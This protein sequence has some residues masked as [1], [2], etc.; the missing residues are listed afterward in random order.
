MPTPVSISPGSRAS[1][2]AFTL[3]ELLVVIAIIAVLI[4]LLLPAVQKVREAANRAKCANNLKQMG[5]AVHN[6][7]DSL[8]KL[9]FIRFSSFAVNNTGDN[10]YTWAV[11]LLPYLEQTGLYQE[12]LTTGGTTG[13]TV[14]G[15]G[16]IRSYKVGDPNRQSSDT[17]RNSFVPVYLCPGRQRRMAKLSPGELISNIFP[18]GT[19]DP[20]IGALVTCSS[21][22]PYQTVYN[23]QP[24]NSGFVGDYAVSC[25][26]AYQTNGSE[27]G[28]FVGPAIDGTTPNGA[29]RFTNVADGLSNTLMLG[30]KYVPAGLEGLANDPGIQCDTLSDGPMF[31][32]AALQWPA[33][34]MHATQA[35]PARDSAIK[36]TGNFGGPHSGVV[37]MCAGDGSVHAV[38]VAVNGN[39]WQRLGTREDGL[40]IDGEW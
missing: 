40:V 2:P 3:V 32:P 36:N 31:S 38:S 18:T 14:T 29:K 19:S 35:L 34:R 37:V 13:G 39:V 20:F 23:E 12:W 22:P 33:R 17:A 16:L 10:G 27:N 8:R 6:H 26:S 11:D 30:E 25:G 28:V 21:S 24:T 9:P 5:L 15:A 1:R 4:G 7:H